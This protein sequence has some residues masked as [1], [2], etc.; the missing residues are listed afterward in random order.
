MIRLIILFVVFFL[1]NPILGVTQNVRYTKLTVQNGL[2]SNNVYGCIQ[3]SE[4]YI[5][6]FTDKGISKYNGS[7]FKTFTVQDGLQTND[8]WD[9]AE[10]KQGRI[11]VFAN[12]D[13]LQYLEND[14]VYDIPVADKLRKRGY[15]SSSFY[16]DRIEFCFHGN[17]VFTLEND[18]LRLDFDWSNRGLGYVLSMFPSKIVLKNDSLLIGSSKHVSV[19]SKSTRNKLITSSNKRAAGDLASFNL[20]HIKLKDGSFLPHYIVLV[21]TKTNKVFDLSF[22]DYF[23]TLPDHAYVTRLGDFLEVQTNLG[24]VVYDDKFN[25]IDKL[26]FQDEGIDMLV[27]KAFIDKQS[28]RWICTQDKGVVFIRAENRSIASITCFDDQNIVEI[29]GNGNAK[30]FC[31]WEGNIYQNSGESCQLILNINSESFARQAS[32]IRDNKIYKIVPYKDKFIICTKYDILLFDKDKKQIKNLVDEETLLEAK[33]SAP[34]AVKDVFYSDKFKAFLIAN[35]QRLV[36]MPVQDLEK[37]SVIN[38][39]ISASS[40][41]Q[42]SDSVCYIGANN[43]LFRLQLD[44]LL[45]TRIYEQELNM[46]IT[47]IVKFDTTILIG[48]DGYGLAYISK[49]KLIFASSTNGEII[50]DI[51][52]VNG[53]VWLSSNKGITVFNVDH[54]GRLILARKL[55]QSVGLMSSEV[56]CLYHDEDKVYTGTKT[57][58]NVVDPSDTTVVNDLPLLYHKSTLVNGKVISKGQN[59]NFRNDDNNFQFVFAGVSFKELN[60]LKYQYSLTGSVEN[61][62]LTSDNTANYFNLAPGNYRFAA[63]AVDLLGMRSKEVFELDFSIEQPWHKRTSSFIIG[64]LLL[65]LLS[66]LIYINRVKKIR[67]DAKL[68]TTI[69]KKFAELELQALRSQMNPHFLFN[70]MN[71]IQYLIDSNQS[72]DASKYLHQFASLM[73]RYLESSKQ[74]N[75]SLVDEIKLLDN[76]L[77]LEQLRL[78]G[79]FTYSINQSSELNDII[80][81]IPSMMVQPFVE[82]AI[83]HGL[84]HKEGPKNLTINFEAVG[85]DKVKC[86]VE[87]NGIGRK[88]AEEIR[89]K[90]KGKHKSLGIKIIK[91]R[92]E[93]LK[94][95]DERFIKIAFED[96]KDNNGEPIGTRVSLVIDVL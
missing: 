87:D 81:N 14:K 72:D 15:Y 19:L 23:H 77:S 6:F 83:V 37:S 51:E 3:D 30:Y 92:I 67:S 96:L 90:S 24:T 5:W 53:E 93:L 41:C 50:S 57:G 2:P 11:W 33:S 60:S 54:N 47:N 94:Q 64:L 42:V 29:F 56:Q 43:G 10:D 4:N 89:I 95:G 62:T 31:D 46:K 1:A 73:R 70:C 78:D 34:I 52:I 25:L 48:T 86:T 88:K 75:I 59:T 74:A 66:Y 20:G 12:G 68:Q 36:Y 45:T 55:S 85:Q 8:V 7:E 44:S 35:N 76:Y 26:V 49:D 69:N 61:K 91:E 22:S 63:Q 32:K 39:D 28:N 27:N 38:L 80:V 18:S 84:F 71:T 79:N 40:I 16:E 58:V 82:N 17:K 65:A 21:N 13:R 9:L